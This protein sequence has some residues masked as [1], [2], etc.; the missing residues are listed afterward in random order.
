MKNGKLQWF[1]GA[2]SAAVLLT[3][4]PVS[5]G[6]DTSKTVT[7]EK[8]QAEESG[9]WED[10]PGERKWHGA[11]KAEHGEWKA[12]H[13]ERRAYRMKRLKEAAQYFGIATEG[14]SAKQLHKELR[15]ASKAD[16]AKWERFR[17]EQSA[18]RLARL[19]SIA[20]KLGIATQG[21]TA[22]QLYRDIRAEIEGIS[23]QRSS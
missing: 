9:Q 6:Y 20:A 15:A 22:R 3:A 10:A 1:V 21:K 13:E 2:V 19:Q 11:A 23:E 17:R 7:P 12:M 4:A 5:A 14:K 8:R 18:K 16:K